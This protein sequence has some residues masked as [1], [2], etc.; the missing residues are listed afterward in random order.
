[1]NPIAKIKEAFQSI[2]GQ[3][4]DLRADAGNSANRIQEL[5]KLVE[6]QREQLAVY[7]SQQEKWENSFA[8]YQEQQA[9]RLWYME[10]DY[11]EMF[12][13]FQMD[14]IEKEYPGNADKLRLLKDAYKGKR[15]FIIGNGPSLRASDLE[16]L[17]GE[18][19]FACNRIPLIFDQT[20][21]RPTFYTCT[22]RVY[23]DGHYEEVCLASGS[24]QVCFVCAR[25]IGCLKTHLDN[26][27]AF[28]MINRYQVPAWFNP[29]VPKG[30]YDGGTVLYFDLQLAAYMGFSEIYL[31][32]ADTNYPTKT[33]PD[34]RVVFD[35]ENSKAYFT[36]NYQTHATAE[37]FES[38]QDLNRM[39]KQGAHNLHKSFQSAKWYLDQY[40]IK[41]Y[42]ATRGGALEVFPRVNF[43]N[44]L[45]EKG[46]SE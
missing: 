9:D 31:L 44:L 17:K 23:W 26:L 46:I 34:G 16:K 28:P 2:D 4:K 10:K 14:K 39:E 1:M 3:L 43:D 35:L 36:S 15:C 41:V 12:A 7:E 25:D 33:M 8:Q 5:E 38:W 24:A 21:W 13:G 27:I 32:G 42:N 45:T 37:W 29:D 11:D 18:I 19:T 40:N 30:V 22:D 6:T 20:D